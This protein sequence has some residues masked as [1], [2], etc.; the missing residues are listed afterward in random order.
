L[1][2]KLGSNFH[3]VEL[4]ITDEP[5]I[6]QWVSKTFSSTYIP[7]ILINN[8]G[9][10]SFNKVDET[11]TAA[12]LAIINTNLN[13]MFYLTSKITAV[14]KLQSQSAH[15]INIGSVIGKVARSEA[16]AYC[17]SKFA[18]SGFSESLF[19]E[20]RQ[21]NIKVTCVNPGSI[22]TDLLVNSGV[23]PHSNMLQPKDIA[24][25]IVHILETPDNMLIDEITV[26]PLN[27]KPPNC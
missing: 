4:D 20:L 5:A 13:G 12:W 2:E 10:G 27:P 3:S 19:M 18:V 25:T 7:N 9:I 6:T 22:E 21:Y 23:Q 15:I 14:M 17:A 1:R 11:S 24:D 8:A 16:T 26:R